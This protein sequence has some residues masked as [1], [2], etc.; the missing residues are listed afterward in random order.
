MANGFGNSNATQRCTYSFGNAFTIVSRLK[1]PFTTKG[2]LKT[3]HA[4][5]ILGWQT[6][7]IF[8]RIV[9]LPD[10]SGLRLGFLSM[11]LNFSFLPV[12]FGL[13]LMPSIIAPFLINPIPRTPFSSLVFG[14]YGCKEIDVAFNILI[15]SLL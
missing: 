5:T 9:F 10:A 7:P 8:S 13:K 3:F 6:F 14:I 1:T 12:I 15:S 11:T 2:S 4:F